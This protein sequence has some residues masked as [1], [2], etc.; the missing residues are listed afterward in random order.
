MGSG[1][2][3]V[4]YSAA[5]RRGRMWLAKGLLKAAGTGREVNDFTPTATWVDAGGRHEH[6]GGR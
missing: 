6:R 4:S 5:G 3:V 2:E 1:H